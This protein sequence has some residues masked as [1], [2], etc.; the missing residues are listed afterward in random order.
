ES[1]EIFSSLSHYKDRCSGETL[2][3]FI[4]IILYSVRGN[5][6]RICSKRSSPQTVTLIDASNCINRNKQLIGRCMDRASINYAA[7]KHENN[8]MKMPHLCW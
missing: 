4:S 7:I 3:N 6:K 2:K 5:L 1:K 8:A